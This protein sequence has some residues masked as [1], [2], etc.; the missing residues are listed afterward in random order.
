MK[1]PKDKYNEFGKYK[2]RSAESIFEEFKKYQE[3]FNV[4]LVVQDAMVAVGNRIYVQATATMYDLETGESV[5]ASAFAREDESL[6]GMSEAQVTGAC[7]SYARK[8]ALGGLFLLDDG[9]DM[10]AVSAEPKEAKNVYAD[11]AKAEPRKATEKQLALIRDLMEQ[12]GVTE[13]QILKRYK[14]KAI[15]DI[16]NANKLINDLMASTGK[17]EENEL[18]FR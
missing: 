14:V 11:K 5:K 8:Y 13:A 15:E 7:S 1:V 16:T 2:Y 4:S 6:K 10:D 17:R 3:A 12:K 18:P 9:K